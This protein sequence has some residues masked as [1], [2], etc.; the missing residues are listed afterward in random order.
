MSYSIELKKSKNA[1]TDIISINN[2]NVYSSYSPFTQ[3]E[4]FLNTQI[5]NTT[6]TVVFFGIALG[7]HIQIVK[8]KYPEIKI[9]AFEPIK[10]LFEIYSS[11][12]I[13]KQNQN[14]KNMFAFY[15]ENKDYLYF[16]IDKYLNYQD[17]NGL[18]IINIYSSL[19]ILKAEFEEFILTLRNLID[20]KH[21][22]FWTNL[23]LSEIWN[24][25]T[26]ENFKYLDKS[27]AIKNFFEKFTNLPAVVVGAGPSLDKSIA[28]LKQ[29][30]DKCLIIAVDTALRA[31]IKNDCMPD[32]VIT[33]DCQ[34]INF[35]DF[36]GLDIYD[37]YLIYELSVYPAILNWYKGDKLI[38]TA[39]GQ[40]TADEYGK[41]YVKFE[42]NFKIIMPYISDIGYIQTGGSVSTLALDFARLMNC[43]PVILLGQ[44]LSYSNLKLHCS[45]A[46]DMQD[47]INNQNKFQ[48]IETI[49]FS[50]L[51]EKS[52]ITT[53]GNYEDFVFTDLVLKHYLNWI[54]DAAKLLK[55]QKNI[56]V[57]NATL[58][59][60]YIPNT[61]LQTLDKI[62][63]NKKNINKKK[64]FEQLSQSKIKV[65]KIRLKKDFTHLIKKFDELITI[66]ETLLTELNASCFSEIKDKCIEY[67]KNILSVD[68]ELLEVYKNKYYVSAKQLSKLDCA[69]KDVIE[70]ADFQLFFMTITDGLRKIND[71]LKLIVKNC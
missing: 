26:A 27:I 58:G 32:F 48:T 39:I 49:I 4:R 33:L 55:E 11:S 8:Q 14:N 16:L 25:N 23:M 68:F 17:I 61:K 67:K 1:D 21:K 45:D 36:A 44:D 50:Q 52:L 30:K 3:I 34:K 6:K 5:T 40:H 47:M 2:Y 7:Y 69:D 59:G 70:K 71:M 38:C 46:F 31:L 19:P 64:L 54:S 56:D 15:Y 63:E 28:T 35:K 22:N 18:T 62:L 24:H 57:I 42:P 9:F 43:N 12:D 66:C 60:A 13:C 65:D 53:K 10:N 29:N 37:F 20:A 51:S 41:N